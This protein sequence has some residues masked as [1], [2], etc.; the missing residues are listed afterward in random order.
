[1]FGS[2]WLTILRDGAR[3]GKKNGCALVKKPVEEKYRRFTGRQGA[4][5]TG[6][7]IEIAK[8]KARALNWR[9]TGAET[10]NKP[11]DRSCF[12]RIN[13]SSESVQQTVGNAGA[14]RRPVV[15]AAR[16]AAM[17]RASRVDGPGSLAGLWVSLG[18]Q[19]PD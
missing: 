11:G 4:P 19:I 13:A 15:T 7:V 6:K 8:E 3:A 1:M 12:G 18:A 9:V 10:G 2:P 17:L 5:N 16:R 14:C